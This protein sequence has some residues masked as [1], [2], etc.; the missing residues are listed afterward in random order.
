MRFDV[1]T[2]LPG[3][4]EGFFRQGVLGRAVE[5]G[6]I[7]ARVWSLRDFAEGA[8]RQTDDTPYGGGA[9]MVMKPEPI[10]R[11]AEAISAE[12]GT[13]PWRVL[14]SPQ[15]RTFDQ[16]KARELAGRRRLLLIC[17]RYEGIDER[18]RELAVDEELSI[19]D[20]VLSGGEVPAM[21]VADAVARLLP[22]VL[23]N[24]ESALHE[25]FSEGLLDHPHYTRPPEF[26]GLRVPEVLL[27]GNHEAIRRWRREAALRR[28]R[29]LRRDLFDRAKL[30][31]ED[32]QLLESSS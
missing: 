30:T 18:V 7:E 23:G 14:L 16:A 28:T 5:R 19:G 9:G 32:L 21:A 12:G 22:G 8:Y 20:Y 15:G 25:S 17:G 11:A 6:V 2:V 3:L 13:L 4:F 31:G 26:R 29:E 24:E 27:T 10:V 1:L